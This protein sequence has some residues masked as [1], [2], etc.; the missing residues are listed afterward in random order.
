[1]AE[2][3]RRRL[4]DLRAATCVTDLL[5]GH[6]REVKGG[7]HGQFALELSERSQIVFCANHNAVP[8]LESGSVD[9]ASVTRIKILR[10]ETN[11][12]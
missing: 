2:N 6:P 9:W 12:D 10:I 4:A 5:A 7:R 11:H 8:L 1:M 3:L